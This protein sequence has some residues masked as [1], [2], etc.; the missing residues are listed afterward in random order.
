M[1][2]QRNT[3]CF[4]AINLMKLKTPGLRS[5][6]TGAF[7]SRL[8]L[9]TEPQPL[10]RRDG[11]GIR[12]E[13]AGGSKTCLNSNPLQALLWCTVIVLTSRASQLSD[14]P[15][16]N[17]YTALQPAYWSVPWFHTPTDQ[18]LCVQLLTDTCFLLNN[19]EPC[20]QRNSY[21]TLD[22]QQWDVSSLIECR[23][24]GIKTA[25]KEQ[26]GKHE[27]ETEDQSESPNRQRDV[28]G[29]IPSLLTTWRGW[30]V[31]VNSRKSNRQWVRGFDQQKQVSLGRKCGGGPFYAAVVSKWTPNLIPKAQCAKVC[32]SKKWLSY[33]RERISAHVLTCTDVSLSTCG[34]WV[35]W[36]GR[37]QSN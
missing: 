6:C 31:A 8:A 3:N 29:E 4:G 25:G 32:A 5:E 10:G 24:N 37:K 9:F 11:I 18:N 14:A 13:L 19:Q 1:S 12:D 23:Q 2:A 22:W 27:G 34:T 16:L 21:V 35:C 36:M 26:E 20:F 7:M 30:T 33:T 28:A 15:W 17:F